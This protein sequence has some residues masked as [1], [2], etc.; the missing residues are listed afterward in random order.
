[1]AEPVTL[2]ARVQHGT[3][4]AY[5]NHRCRCDECRTTWGDYQRRW[6]VARKGKAAAATALAILDE[7]VIDADGGI[8]R[9]SSDSGDCARLSD[10]AAAACLGRVL[11]T[12]GEAR[13]G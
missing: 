6:R 2:P 13:R 5:A 11:R 7:L 4:N 10:A 9:V 1:M 3:I 8:W 12:L